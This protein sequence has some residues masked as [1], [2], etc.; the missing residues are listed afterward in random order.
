MNTQQ[1][2][3]TIQKAGYTLTIDAYDD[4]SVLAQIAEKPGPDGG[5]WV[6]AKAAGKTLHKTVQRCWQELKNGSAK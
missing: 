6:L 1:L 4:G 2:I 5:Q 3:K